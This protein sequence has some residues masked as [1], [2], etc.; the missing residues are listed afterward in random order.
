MSNEFKIT[1]ETPVS[2]IFSRITGR[3]RAERQKLGYSQKIFSGRCGVPLRTYKRFEL[4]ECDSLE[5]FL[6]IIKEF[7]RLTAVELLFPPKPILSPVTLNDPVASLSKML[8]RLNES[9]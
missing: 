6:R 5:V 9:R 8:Q 4:G 3:V 7:D 2:T 1:K